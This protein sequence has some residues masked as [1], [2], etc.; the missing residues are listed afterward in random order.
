MPLIDGRKDISRPYLIQRGKVKPGPFTGID[1]LVNY[2]YMGASEFEF[3]ALSRSLNGLTEK[4]S[5][6]VCKPIDLNDGANRVWIISTEA[7][8]PLIAVVLKSL[9][10]GDQVF[11]LHE[12]TEFKQALDGNSDINFWWEIESWTLQ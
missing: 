7:E 4:M 9:A 11:N 8:F 6:L 10:R 3:G 1:S 2:D 5:E 12:R